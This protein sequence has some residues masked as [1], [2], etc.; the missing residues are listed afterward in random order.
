MTARRWQGTKRL[1]GGSRL[2]PPHVLQF[3]QVFRDHFGCFMFRARL[4]WRPGWPRSLS[5][6]SHERPLPADYPRVWHVAGADSHLRVRD[7]GVHAGAASSTSPL[8]LNLYKHMEVKNR[9]V[10]WSLSIPVFC[11]YTSFRLYW[12]NSSAQTP[13]LA[14]NGVLNSGFRLYR[15]L[16]AV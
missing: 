8:L 5:S 10:Q 14:A 3:R 1:T 12:S 16:S 4:R 9:I 13:N 11:L 2:G 15:S 6:S 7:K